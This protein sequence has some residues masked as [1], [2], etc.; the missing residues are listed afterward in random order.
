MG[1]TV[2]D[3]LGDSEGCAVGTGEG[4]VVG[5]C[6]GAEVLHLP[7]RAS[8]WLLLQSESEVHFW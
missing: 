7:A 8:H 5:A 1:A 2:G 4:V 3:A 6:V